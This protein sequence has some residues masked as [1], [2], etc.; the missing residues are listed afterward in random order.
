MNI[1]VA[2]G[3]DGVGFSFVKK[4]RKNYSNVNKIYIIGR[5]FDKL[6]NYIP[7][8]DEDF[9][10]EPIKCDISK[11]IDLTQ[12]QENSIDIFVNTIGSFVK[13]KDF[14]V[15]DECVN[16]NITCNIRLT[17]LM[18]NKL[19]KDA[20]IVICSSSLCTK[21][22]RE[23]YGLQGA[24]KV[25]YQYYIDSLRKTLKKTYP[26]MRVMSILPDGLNTDI[27]EKGGDKRDVSLYPSPDIVTDIMFFQLKLPRNITIPNIVVKNT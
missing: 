11:E 7:I 9:D 26:R 24:C 8:E 6:E 4:I 25:G 19:K 20:Q 5:N 15:F 14:D 2:G 3:T 16:L 12:V 18:L 27:F 21:K 17:N 10:Y 22:G 13:D 1:L 23:G